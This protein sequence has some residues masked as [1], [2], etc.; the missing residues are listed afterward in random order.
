[1]GGMA[2]GMIGSS[3]ANHHHDEHNRNQDTG[4]Y[5]GNETVS[6]FAMQSPVC[7]VGNVAFWLVAM[8]VVFGYWR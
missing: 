5:R 1:M 6:S 4:N 3:I 2:G 7:D 8:W